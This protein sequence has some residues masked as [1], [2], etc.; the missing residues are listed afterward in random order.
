MTPCPYCGEWVETIEGNCCNCDKDLFPDYRVP[1]LLAA[2]R[3][4]ESE[5]QKEATHDH[6]PSQA[7]PSRR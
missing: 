3:N 1:Y 7:R 4:E 5:S 2:K 6:R